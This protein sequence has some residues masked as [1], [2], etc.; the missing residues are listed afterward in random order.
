MKTP[1]SLARGS[2]RRRIPAQ[3]FDLVAEAELALDH[4]R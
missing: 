4:R 2:V 3:P 1:E